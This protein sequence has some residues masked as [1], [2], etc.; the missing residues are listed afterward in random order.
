MGGALKMR[1]GKARIHW[2]DL[3]DNV[4]G[5]YE[6]KEGFYSMHEDMDEP[7]Y[8]G[9]GLFWW[10]EGNAGCDCNR[11]LFFRGLDIECGDD[12]FELTKFE[13]QPKGEEDWITLP[14]KEE[15]A[16]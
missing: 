16:S 1:E 8:P 12:R 5:V 15:Y 11:G 7:P 9:W 2:K 6:D 4:E 3:L 13:V 10:T 14:Y